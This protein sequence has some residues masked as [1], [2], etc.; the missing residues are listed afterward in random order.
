MEETGI[1]IKER[2]DGW[3]IF[4][5]IFCQE[6]D[7]IETFVGKTKGLKLAIKH[8]IEAKTSLGLIGILHNSNK[9]VIRLTFANGITIAS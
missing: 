5:V 1:I 4:K 9:P 7:T 6:G 2:P 3:D 8:G